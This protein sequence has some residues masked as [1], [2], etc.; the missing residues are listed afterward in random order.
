[1]AA[2]QP[3]AP[4]E[5]SETSFVRNPAGMSVASLEAARNAKLRLEHY[6][7]ITVDQA[8]ERSQR[9]ALS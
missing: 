1:M 7:R 4:G 2:S 3:S 5:S 9:C 6:Y 8:V